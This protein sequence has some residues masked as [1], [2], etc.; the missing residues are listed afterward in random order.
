MAN[1]S[2]IDL[3]QLR[4]F[5]SVINAGSISKASKLLHIAQSALS[6]RIGLLEHSIGVDLIHRDNSGVQPTDQGMKLYQAAQRILR[7]M[8]NVVDEINTEEENPVGHLRVGSLFSLTGLFGAP[9][10]KKSLSELPDVKLSVVAGTS[11]EVYRSLI[12]GSVDIALFVWDEEAESKI[13]SKLRILEDI[14][15]VS[16]PDMPGL[17]AS[18]SLP[19]E[20]IKSLPFLFPTAKTFASGRQ[21]MSHFSQ[22]GIDL[23]VKAEV[24][25]DGL[26]LL[27]KEGL[28]CGIFSGASVQSEVDAGKL[29]LRFLENAPMKRKLVLCTNADRPKTVALRAVLKL[30]SDTIKSQVESGA[31]PHAVIEQ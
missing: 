16:S 31:W 15:I 12:D 21:V 27:I 5:V 23:N 20:E 18:D 6:K 30:A 10:V 14:F 19:P 11:S 22:M 1:A 2:N 3:K 26:K 24:D 8:E 29:I 7:D 17:P 25:G 28:G 4:Y 9:L 13:E